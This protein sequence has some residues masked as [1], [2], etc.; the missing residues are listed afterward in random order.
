[1]LT[2][3]DLG[4]DSSPAGEPEDDFFSSW[5]K[6][7]IKR[8]T[9]PISRTATPPVIGRTASP[10]SSASNG[11]KDSP[12]PSSGLAKP[13]GTSPSP[14]DTGKPAPASRITHSAGLRKTGA[15]GAAPRRA[16][17]LGAKKA[18]AKLGVKKVSA[19][20]I[21]FD[22][23]EKRAKEEA[24]RI[25]KLGYDPEDE[26]AGLDAG[27][28]GKEASNVLAPTPA[29]PGR[30]GGGFGATAAPAKS[31]ADTERLGMG[32][33]RLGFGQVGASKA[34]AAAGQKKMGGFG[35]VGPIKSA[36]TS[37]FLPFKLQPPPPPPSFPFNPQQPFPIS[38]F[39]Y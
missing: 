21:D 13:P 23:A 39:V 17:V 15:G 27:K 32:M 36:S 3:G 28:K 7:A 22:E 38:L 29:S 34:A 14:S 11:G 26:A 33:A 35:S 37:M 9:P 30:G 25:E 18:T 2:E 12:R 5:D 20:L 6:P 10:L 4:A 16:N 8:P 24:E 19:D 1:M 31:G